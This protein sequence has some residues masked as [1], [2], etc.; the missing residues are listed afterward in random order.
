[1]LFEA[2]ETEVRD[3]EQFV[4][5]QRETIDEIKSNI[6]KL[7][8]Y[9]EVI[10]FISTMTHNLEGARPAQGGRDA[11]NPG[12]EIQAESSLQFIAGTV[13]MD[14]MERMKKMLFRITR[15]RALTH[16]KPFT[17]EDGVE[18]VAYLVV[19]SAAGGNKERVQKIC[20][21]FMGQRF[22]IPDLNTLD[23]VILEIKE[24]IKKA[25][26]LR[27]T[28]IGQL[29]DYLYDLNSSKSHSNDSEVSVLEIYKWFVA[30]EKAI[31]YAMNQLKLHRQTFIGYMWLPSEKEGVIAQKLQHFNTTEFTKWRPAD[32]KAGPTPPSS[33]KTNDM[34]EFHQITVDMYKSATY[35][36]IN[37][38]I[39]QI[40]TFPFLYAVMYGDYGHGAI[41]LLL[42]SV[43]CLFEGKLRKNPAMKGLL[44]TR[45]FWLMMGFFACYQGLIYNEFFAI[46][47]D[48]F[49]T[50]YD[51]PGYE[52]KDYKVDTSQNYISYK[53][54]NTDCV[55]YFGMDPAQ[56]LSV[57]YLT[58]TNNIKEKLAVII[59][60]FH[61]NF[62]MFV[63]ALN[64][65]YF[66]TW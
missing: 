9:Y 58:Y 38:A 1:M 65:V 26:N 30:K 4:V 60:Y 35:G 39:F 48:W 63:N 47:N 44:M 32:G 10:K 45:Y 55:Y 64:C 53:N 66:R 7:E 29:K 8:D 62:G 15:G 52:Q 33:Y 17:N 2:I 14:E 24:K 23:E 54:D 21:S 36:E 3:C 16:F 59:A 40:V 43:L 28:S 46:N 41:F 6:G 42:G 37:P 34:L 20:D 57:N 5:T 31:Y 27:D 56:T 22:E 12:N 50:C 51:I 19:F 18:K 49:G 61:L 13:K 11:E 25:I